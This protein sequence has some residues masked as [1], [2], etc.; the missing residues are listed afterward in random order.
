MVR[1]LSEKKAVAVYPRFKNHWILGADTVVLIKEAILGKPL[2]HAE[3]RSMLHRLS[4]KDHIVLTGMTIIDPSGQTA[5][6]EA[7]RTHVAVKP[8][9]DGEME[10]YIRTGEPFGKAGGY[11]IQGIGAFMVSSI[12]GSYTN[13]VGLPLCAL[14]KALE[15]IG[16]I[17][18]FPF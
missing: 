3:A 15:K 18:H 7:V 14:V 1:Y 11:A 6:R 5:F 4:G 9:S 2:D 17:N 16:A 12:S 8:L 10:G 13:V